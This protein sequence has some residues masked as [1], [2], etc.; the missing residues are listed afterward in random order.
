MAIKIM[1][2]I[3]WDVKKGNAISLH[4]PNGRVVMVDCGVSADCSPVRVLRAKGV[5]NIDWLVI[6]HPH[7]DHMA[8]ISTIRNLG[9]GP[10]IL[11]CPRDI[12]DE[13][14]WEG[15]TDAE[16]VKHYLTAKDCYCG[17]VG[18]DDNMFDPVCTGGVTFKLFTPSKRVESDLN[19]RSRV[20]VAE[21][22]CTK[23][24]LPGDCTP[25]AMKELLEARD[26]QNAIAGTTILLAP[27]HG[28]ESCY[29]SELMEQINPT[30]CIISDGK[31]P[32][33]VNAVDMYG[34]KCH[35]MM[36]WNADGRKDN[37]QCLTTRSDGHIVVDVYDLPGGF[38]VRTTN[39]AGSC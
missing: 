4:L 9:M 25:A 23:I 36:F 18:A 29:C 12:S 31:V 34:R 28:H 8:D 21:Y 38:S 24:V 15:N 39:G 1:R 10:S 32:A 26:F 20:V 2:M 5:Q 3:V 14:V 33:S 7:A 37:R 19:N 27:H 17:P 22:G 11:L 30:L 16:V 35:G 13:A 6:T